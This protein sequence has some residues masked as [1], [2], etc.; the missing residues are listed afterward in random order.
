MAQIFRDIVGDS[1]RAHED[2]D[3]GVLGTDLIQVLDRFRTLLEIS[4]DVDNLL[5]VVVRSEFHR[6]Y[7]DLIRDFQEVLEDESAL[8]HH[9]RSP[10]TLA[11]FWTGRIWLTILRI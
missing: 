6:A 10:L 1:F 4:D 9:N 2:Q 11:S 5:N 7:F 8:Q 3:F